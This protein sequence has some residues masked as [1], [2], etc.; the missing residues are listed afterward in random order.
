MRNFH[1]FLGIFRPWS[2]TSHE[3]SGGSNLEGKNRS[4]GLIPSNLQVNY[5]LAREASGNLT[6]GLTVFELKDGNVMRRAGISIGHRRLVA[7]D[8]ASSL[9]SL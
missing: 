5:H 2:G 4:L 9:N 1:S 8:A 6:E 3:E 7:P